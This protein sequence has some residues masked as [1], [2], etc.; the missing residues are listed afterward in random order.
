MALIGV[1]IRLRIIAVVLRAKAGEGIFAV[2][3]MFPFDMIPELRVGHANLS[4]D[5]TLAPQ[6]LRSAPGHLLPVPGAGVLQEGLLGETDERHPLVWTEHAAEDLERVRLFRDPDQFVKVLD[7]ILQNSVL[8]GDVFD[9][10]LERLE[11]S[12]PLLTR[13]TDIAVEEFVSMKPPPE[14]YNLV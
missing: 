5:P 7:I 1:R 4:A 11:A 2:V 13:L 10:V 12:L 6:F 8:S 9:Y 14:Q 3:E